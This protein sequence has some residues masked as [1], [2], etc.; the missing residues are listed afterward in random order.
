[1]ANNEF[2]ELKD[3]IVGF[4]KTSGE[5]CINGIDFLYHNKY[6]RLT[7][8]QSGDDEFL[9]CLRVK[10]DKPKGCIELYELPIKTYPNS[11]ELSLSIYLGLY[12]DISDVLCNAKI[13]DVSIQDVI[14]SPETLILG[15]D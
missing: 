5:G 9:N 4:S 8:E 14:I 12:N 3:F 1:M 15:I 2:K 13:E 10:Y 6:Y 11:Y 7:H